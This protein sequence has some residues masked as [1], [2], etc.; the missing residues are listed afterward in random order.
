MTKIFKII[1]W[2][3]WQIALLVEITPMVANS[4]FN[5]LIYCII[6]FVADP[7]TDVIDGFTT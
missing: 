5:Y 2:I 3:L 4:M 1:S 7:Y 6:F